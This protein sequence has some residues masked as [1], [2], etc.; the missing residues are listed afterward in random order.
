MRAVNRETR[1]D[2]G[3]AWIA[4]TFDTY[5]ASLQSGTANPDINDA[6]ILTPSL[7]EALEWA[8]ARTEWVMVRPQWDD[9]GTYYWAGSGPVPERHGVSQVAV[10][11]LDP[12]TIPER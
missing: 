8:R 3:R 11:V 12:G 2:N 4:W 5:E 1:D 10:P 6:G 7:A 9:S